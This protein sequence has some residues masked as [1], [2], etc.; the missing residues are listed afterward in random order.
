MGISI[1]EPMR[2]SSIPVIV[3]VHEING[4]IDKVQHTAALSPRGLIP[5]QAT[6]SSGD[7]PPFMM[8]DTGGRLSWSDPS[9][10]Q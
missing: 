3:N 4:I 9:T 5:V 7:Q 10:A 6:H 8:V 2:V 1:N